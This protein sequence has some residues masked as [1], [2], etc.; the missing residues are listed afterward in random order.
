MDPSHHAS[1]ATKAAVHLADWSQAPRATKAVAASVLVLVALGLYFLYLAGGAFE[2]QGPIRIA[3]N[4]SDAILVSAYRTL[5]LIDSERRLTTL[6]ATDLG[7]RGPLTSLTADDDEWLIGDDYS[8]LLHRCSALLKKCRP[9]IASLDRERMFSRA[10]GVAFL[11]E[12]IV[13]ADSERHRLRVFDT[14][15]GQVTATRTAPIELCYPND[16]I[17]VDGSLYVADTN[18]FRIARIDAQDNFRSE[19]F[20]Q[21]FD[22]KAFTRSNCADVSSRIAK[23]GD[24]YVNFLLDASVTVGRPAMSPARARRIL[25]AS[26]LR[27]GRDEWWV[28]QMKDMMTMGDVIVYANDGTPMKRIA[29]PENSAPTSLFE[30]RDG[31]LIADPILS[32]IY[33]VALDGTVRGEWGSTELKAAFHSILAARAHRERLKPVSWGVFALALLLGL[34]VIVRELVRTKGNWNSDRV[35]LQPVDAAPMPLDEPE[36][37]LPVTAQFARQAWWFS[38]LGVAAALAF[39]GVEGYLLFEL[40]TATGTNA[41]LPIHKAVYLLAGIVVAVGAALIGSTILARRQMHMRIGTD[42]RNLLFDPG[43]GKIASCDFERVLVSGRALLMHPRFVSTHTQYGKAIYPMDRFQSLI[44]ARIPQHN[45]IKP[46]RFAYQALKRGNFSAW[47]LSV[48]TAFFLLLQLFA[49]LFR[50]PAA[51]ITRFF[52]T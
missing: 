29:L 43:N 41:A 13:V 24:A 7:L 48:L 19:T 31:V 12:Q 45:F 6:D 39:L 11:G 22:G 23:R 21:T 9:L 44:L 52:T 18:N 46:T 42:G 1:Q 17:A 32:R 36:V 35:K 25:P 20:I 28:I 38:W 30:T 34:I 15:T 40:A 2:M 51:A 50:T 14:K 4:S 8:G 16:L 33:D 26:L 3:G 37:W 27:T 10:H 5:F 47:A 49:I